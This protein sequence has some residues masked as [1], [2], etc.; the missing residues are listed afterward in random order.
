[1]DRIVGI[2]RRHLTVVD[3]KKQASTIARPDRI[4]LPTEHGHPDNRQELKRFFDP[5]TTCVQERT[6]RS[7]RRLGQIF[8]V[9]CAQPIARFSLIM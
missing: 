4:E 6:V 9:V 3:Q 2:E 7:R 1:M 5:E 8:T